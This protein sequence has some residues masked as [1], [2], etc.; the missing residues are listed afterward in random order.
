MSDK[1]PTVVPK[2]VPKPWGREDWLV[3][4][5][6]IVMKRLVVHAGQRFSLQLHREKEEA[7][8]FVRG[9]ARL[10]LG[11]VEGE[12]VPGQV[13]HVAP[14]TIHRIEAL[15]E[16]EFLE[17]STPELTDVVRLEDDYGRAGT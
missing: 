10:R 9:R 5:A 7:W 15:E 8:L 4:G 13:I 12:V 16:L 1:I 11:G 17:V 6:R 3:V 14:G 2:I